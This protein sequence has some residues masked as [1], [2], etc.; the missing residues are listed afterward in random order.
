MAE[1]KK[2]G[3]N[4][5]CPCG[6]GRKY[7]KCCLR[8]TPAYP[9]RQVPAEIPEEV[10]RLFREHER[11]ERERATRYGDIRPQIS[12]EFQGYRMVAVGNRLHY[13]KKW[14]FFPDFLLDHVPAVFGKD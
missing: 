4:D 12:M 11:A 7:K 8:P 14:K 1:L 6:S 10:L 9:L 5:L 13:S 3:R 2:I